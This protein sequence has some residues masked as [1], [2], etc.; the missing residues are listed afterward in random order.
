M[1]AR[2]LSLAGT[3]LATF[4]LVAPVHAEVDVTARRFTA[5]NIFNLEAARDPRISPDGSRI[6]YVR[7]AADI[8]T[9]RYRSSLWIIDTATG[10]QRALVTGDAS[11]SDPVWSPD[12]R[13]LLYASNG[14]LR[15]LSLA[16]GADWPLGKVPG[17]AS[18]AVWAPDGRTIAFLSFV[19]GKGPRFATP[20]S[21]PPGA[22]WEPPA[23]VYDSLNV[24]LDGMGFVKPGAMQLFV[25]PAEGGTPRAVTQGTVSY[26]GLEWL[27]GA[28]VLVTGNAAPDAD[29][30]PRESEIYRIAIATGAVT[31]LTD[32]RGP[33]AE[34]SVSPD[35]KLIA[36][37][38]YDDR[39]VSW[40]TS[41]LYVMNRDGSGRRSLTAA[42]DRSVSSPVW[43]PDGRSLFATITNEG[44][45]ELVR[46]GLD[47]KVATIVTDMNDGAGGRPYIG[48]SFSLSRDG[49]QV[50]YSQGRPDRPSDIALVTPGGKAKRL[51]DVNADALDSVSMA[52]VEKLPVTSS[53]DGRAIDAWVALPPGH[54]PSKPYPL[55]LEIHGGPAIMY[56]PGFASEIQRF[57]AEGFVVVWANQRG[58]LGYGEAFALTIDL[59]YP[60]TDD[61]ADLMSVV[62]AAIAKGLADPAR[63]F[64]T[65][66]SAGGAMT[67]WIVGNT[68]RFAAAVAVNPVINWT[69]TMLA[70]DTA[71]HV[72]RHQVRAMPWED[73]EIFWRLSPLSRV[74][75]VKTPT[76]LMVGDD[77]WRTP[78]AEAEQFYTALKLRGVET[79]LVRI[80]GSGH[81]IGV[82]PTQQIAKTDNI[83]GWFKAHDPAQAEK[84]P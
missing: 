61:L 48:G 3:M 39:K 7:R 53:A 24:H 28:H 74:G 82:R 44:R 35:G 79:A 21:P 68:D 73:R 80:P 36:F 52:R 45:V 77:D 76:M 78:P 49:K 9:D 60:G 33:D 27:D 64:V 59:K 2:A 69:S 20:P 25:V 51:T 41:Q 26:G 19:D 6:V 11:A 62:D 46:V 84:S 22:D 13:R 30:D 83:I 66:G 14:E 15:V 38:G 5:M 43:A 8:R 37:T 12:G 16:E 4:M 57:A 72:A 65:G 71:A 58:S 23:K 18:G 40:Q 29:M 10:E 42:L 70:G 17:G 50:A 55:I 63:L 75:Q 54:D 34:P 32:R 1:K 81:N 67:A 47:G 56:G 31:A